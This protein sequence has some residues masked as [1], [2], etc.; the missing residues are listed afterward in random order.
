[1][2]SAPPALSPPTLICRCYSECARGCP[3]GSTARR[4]GGS[5]SEMPAAAAAAA[6][7]GRGCRQRQGRRRTRRRPVQT[8]AG[9]WLFLRALAAAVL[10]LQPQPR[11]A[12]HALHYCCPCTALGA[13][14]GMF[15]TGS[16]SGWPQS[17]PGRLSIGGARGAPRDQEKAQQTAFKAPGCSSARR[18]GRPKPHWQFGMTAQAAGEG[19]EQTL[20]RRGPQVD[21]GGG[22][23][24]P[25]AAH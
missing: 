17:A 18:Q 15:A 5:T 2:I 23:G 6:V 8:P 7:L 25:A 10:L 16:G 20:G 12:V 3:S 14:W 4:G 19:C 13:S 9:V 21:W 22:R 24:G 1:M 11:T